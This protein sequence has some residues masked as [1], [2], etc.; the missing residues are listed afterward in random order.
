MCPLVVV[1][2]STCG[3]LF[4]F[5]SPRAVGLSFGAYLVAFAFVQ[6]AR[7]SRVVSDRGEGGEGCSCSTGGCLACLAKR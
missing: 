7:E 3:R 2:L 5:I 1:V 6:Y 4:A